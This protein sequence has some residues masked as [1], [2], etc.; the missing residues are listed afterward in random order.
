MIH[1]D[2]WEDFNTLLTEMG[3]YDGQRDSTLSIMNFLR[4]R[5]IYFHLL[6]RDKCVLAFET[7]RH[8]AV[9]SIKYGH[10]L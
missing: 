5:N 4:E 3:Y 1:F 10:I 2:S 8:E 6:T 7:D 9:F